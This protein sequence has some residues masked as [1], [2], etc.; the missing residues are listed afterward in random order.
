M[1]AGA[2]FSH[3]WRVSRVALHPRPL[4]FPASRRLDV[5]PSIA[6]AGVAIVAVIDLVSAVTPNVMWRGHLLVD[7]EPVGI[8]RAAHALA[9]PVSFALLITAYYLF[10]RR[11]RALQL[12]LA[13]L[14]ALAV[15]NIIKG[16]DVEEALVTA[17]GAALLSTSPESFYVP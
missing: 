1:A 6:A 4:R 13:L 15:F 12:A 3:P 7:V 9:V 5:V 16:L 17:A 11:S 8:M 10:R 2:I 14:S